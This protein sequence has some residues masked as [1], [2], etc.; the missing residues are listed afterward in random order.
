[1]LPLNKPLGVTTGTQT[2]E[3]H[4][5]AAKPKPL[6]LGEEPPRKTSPF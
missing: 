5:P 3:Y 6:K 2:H 4:E 1:M